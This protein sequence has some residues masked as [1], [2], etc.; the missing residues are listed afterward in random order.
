MYLRK[1]TVV[2]PANTVWYRDI[3]PG[4]IP[5]FPDWIVAQPEVK[6]FMST[7]I[8]ENTQENVLVFN[9]KLSCAEFLIKLVQNP[10]WIARNV[11]MVA[12]NQVSTISE[13]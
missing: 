4:F 6:Y 7:V 5:R 12:N 8:D 13:L 10:D 1:T 11:H 9:S 2:K 3:T